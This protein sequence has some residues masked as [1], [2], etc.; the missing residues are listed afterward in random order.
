MNHASAHPLTPISFS[1]MLIMTEFHIREVPK[2]SIKRLSSC[3]L[4]WQ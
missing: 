4:S 3:E 1:Y 2:T